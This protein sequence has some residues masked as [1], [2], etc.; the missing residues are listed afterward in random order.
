MDRKSGLYFY[1]RGYG[2][3]LFMDMEIMDVDKKQIWIGRSGYAKVDK[4]GGYGRWIGRS[5]YAKTDK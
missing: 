1:W 4:V 2:V 3:D 5:G